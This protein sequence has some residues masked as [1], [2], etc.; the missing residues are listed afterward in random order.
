M[1]FN[2]DSIKKYLQN[3]EHLFLGQKFYAPIAFSNHSIIFFNIEQKKNFCCFDLSK[4]HPSFYIN[5]TD[6]YFESCNSN[7]VSKLRSISNEFMIVAYELVP[8]DFVIKFRFATSNNEDE[9]LFLI[10]ELFQNHPNLIVTDAKNIVICAFNYSKTGQPEIGEKYKTEEPVNLKDGD[11]IFDDS[12]AEQ[13]FNELI[14]IRRLEKYENFI[15]TY[16]V[17]IKKCRTKINNILDDKKNAELQ[18]K[19]QQ[20]ADNLL[21]QGLDLKG[22]FDHVEIDGERIDLDQSKTLNDNIQLMYKKAKKAKTTLSLIE[23]NLNRANE[24]IRLYE[25][26]LEKISNTESEKDA[27]KIVSIYSQSKKKEVA[28]TEFNKPWKI[29]YQGVYFYFG[30]NASQ[31]DYLS[32]VMKQDRQFIWMHI[33]NQP[34]SHVVISSLK[35]TEDQL[36]FGAELALYF[37]KAKSGEIQYTKKKNIRRGHSLGEAIVKNYSTIKINNIRERSLELFNNIKR[38]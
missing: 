1:R 36:L 37:S 14:K 19:Y 34:G 11:T 38:N 23:T 7:F 28:I 9:D 35:P 20:I 16:E 31:N 29:N 3:N 21:I 2:H 22:H 18:I 6:H 24:E 27:D 26:V 10:F 8:N 15:S 13:L 4:E 25:S 5:K 17:K 12:F 32:F 33:K 30:K